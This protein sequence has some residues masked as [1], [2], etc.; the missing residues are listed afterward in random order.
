MTPSFSFLDF[1]IRIAPITESE[2]I[3][4]QEGV[5]NLEDLLRKTAKDLDLLI[6]RHVYDV[7][8]KNREESRKHANKSITGA[9]V[10]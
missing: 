2:T 6:A 9:D 4:R 5:E 3:L 1:Q 7:Q 8:K 10:Q